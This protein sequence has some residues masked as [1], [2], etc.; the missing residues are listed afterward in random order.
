M[1]EISISGPVGRIEGRFHRSEEQNAPLAILLHHHPMLG[2]TMNN[3][4]IHNLYYMFV[5]RNFSAL[6]FNFRG[7]GRSIGKFDYGHGELSDAAS[8]MDWATANSSDPKACWIVGYSF[9]AWVGMQLLMRR[10]EIKGFIAVSP[11]TNLFNFDFLS[12][13]PSS[14]LIINGDKDKV[15]PP[16]SIQELV[17]RLKSQEGIEIEHK[18]VKSANH[19]F[20]KKTDRLVKFC[21][22]YLDMRIEKDF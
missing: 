19:F 15:V 3:P 20:E 14:G 17:D 1:P 18:M 12:P 21:G 6:R 7:V 8:V 10:P 4:V 16:E 9:G 22:D 5:E 13:C 2:G 11:P